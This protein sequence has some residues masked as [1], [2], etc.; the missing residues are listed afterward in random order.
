MMT[1]LLREL[2]VET[3]KTAIAVEA[4][5]PDTIPVPSGGPPPSL[6]EVRSRVRHLFGAASEEVFHD[7]ME[8]GFSRAI[9]SLVRDYGSAAL[10][11]IQEVMEAPSRSFDATSEALRWLGEID[12]PKTRSE[13][14]Q[15]LEQALQHPSAKV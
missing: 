11:A 3:V 15:M 7:G 6:P 10:E 14:L 5:V 12:D 1:E 2:E 9:C 8:S 13:R 4:R